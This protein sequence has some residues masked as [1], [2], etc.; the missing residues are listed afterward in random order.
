MDDFKIIYRILKCIYASM[1]FDDFN[2]ECLSPEVLHVSQ[3]KVDALLVMLAKD[4]LVDNVKVIRY[5]GGADAV[6]FIGKPALTLK[7]LEYLE[8]NSMMK[9]AKEALSGIA[10]IVL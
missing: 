5:P 4:G 6:K 10:S 3:N 1:D 9:R 2:R 8:D 7:G